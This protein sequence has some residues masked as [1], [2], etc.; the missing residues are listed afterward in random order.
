MELKI[1]I[2]NNIKSEL[3]AS[4]IYFQRGRLEEQDQLFDRVA[5][6]FVALITSINPEIKDKFF[7]VRITG[8]QGST[9]TF[10]SLK[11]TGGNRNV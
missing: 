1:Q 9:L 5:D 11:K 3:N 7:Q 8:R 10:A 4:A 6:S 2:H